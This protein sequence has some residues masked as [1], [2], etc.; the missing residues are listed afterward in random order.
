M[1]FVVSSRVNG[2]SMAGSRAGGGGVREVHVIMHAVDNSTVSYVPTYIHTSSQAGLQAWR[3]LT[4]SS[5]TRSEHEAVCMPYIVVKMAGVGNSVVQYLL[6]RSAAHTTAARTGMA[7][8]H[9][10]CGT[11]YTRFVHV[12]VYVRAMSNM[13]LCRV[14]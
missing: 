8:S 13:Q 9:L 14:T 12:Y 5:A 4:I 10:L 1:Q 2:V 6:S 7:T 11:L 3:E